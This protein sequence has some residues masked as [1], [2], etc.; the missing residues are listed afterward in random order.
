VQ[1]VQGNVRNGD[2]RSTFG[3]CSNLPSSSASVFRPLTATAAN[4]LEGVS[5]G[6]DSRITQCRR[7][8]RQ[9]TWNRRRPHS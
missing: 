6:I 5:T 3:S 7:D 1:T 8:A 9:P 4:A 2:K